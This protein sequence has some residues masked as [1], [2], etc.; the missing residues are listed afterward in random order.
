MHQSF[1]HLCPPGE[2][3][4]YKDFDTKGFVGILG[5]VLLAGDTACAMQELLQRFLELR[6]RQTD[7]LARCGPADDPS[8]GP[9]HVRE[10]LDG[11]THAF[12]EL[13]AHLFQCL[14]FGGRFL[15]ALSQWSEV[16]PAK[17]LSESAV[18]ARAMDQNLQ[19][20][21]NLTRGLQDA[22]PEEP[23]VKSSK[24]AAKARS[25]G[26]NIARAPTKAFKRRTADGRKEKCTVKLRPSDVTTTA[27]APGMAVHN[28]ERQQVGCYKS[29]RRKSC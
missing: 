26:Q 13:E 9:Q 2:K 12:H 11:T 1:E 22:R 25:K 24:A 3:H 7:L 29:L 27:E 23:K 6:K 14:E 20:L 21:K 8:H 17:S 5:P 18:L 10:A 4:E 15:V 28:Q 19:S 16:T